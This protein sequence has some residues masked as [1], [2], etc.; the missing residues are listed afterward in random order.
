MY[1]VVIQVLSLTIKYYLF[2][3]GDI[4]CADYLS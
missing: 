2:V 1:K 3:E 4:A